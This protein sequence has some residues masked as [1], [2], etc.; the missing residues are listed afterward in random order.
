MAYRA[1][2]GEQ[3]DLNEEKKKRSNSKRQNDP[4]RRIGG[5]IKR[6]FS[7][8][9]PKKAED[10][11]QDA[12]DKS[13]ERWE[14]LVKD[15]KEWLDER[16]DEGLT[17]SQTQLKDALDRGDELT[18]EG[19]STLLSTARTYVDQIAGARDLGIAAIDDAISK[20]T[21]GRDEALGVWDAGLETGKKALTQWEKAMGLS[22]GFDQQTFLESLPGY[23]FRMDTGAQAVNRA[24]SA[25]GGTLGGRALKELTAF[26]QGLAAEY[27]GDY[28]DDLG[29]GMDLYSTS[30]TGY[31]NTASNYDNMLTQ[32]GLGKGNIYSQYGSTVGAIGTSLLG[33]LQ[34]LYGT[35][36]SGGYNASNQHLANIGS[37]YGQ[38]IHAGVTAQTQSTAGITQSIQDL[39][40]VQ[41]ANALQRGVGWDILESVNVGLTKEL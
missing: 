25:R 7:T 22:E 1:S 5:G 28:M 18:D 39:A 29:K 20:V 11:Q 21:T 15:T 26:G 37:L 9:D 12:T 23:N 10:A 30:A 6:L 32:L 24:A 3:V 31:S 16:T 17:E 34:N 38:G 27:W 33:G 36:I 35:N 40:N 2:T 13:I 19:V 41:A 4:I 14:N 8:G